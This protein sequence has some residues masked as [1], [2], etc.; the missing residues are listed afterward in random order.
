[1]KVSNETKI[2]ALTVITIVLLFFGFNFLK[3][4]NV[5]Q[6]GFILKAKFAKSKGIQP[7]N[8]V[9]INGFQ[10]GTVSSIQAGD[11]DLSSV[12]V[13]MKLNEAYNI[14]KNSLAIIQ[15]SPLGSSN[16]VIEKG[17]ASQYLAA[18]ES[19]NTSEGAAGIMA[20]LTD[21]LG[22]ISDGLTK[23]MVDFDSLLL[24]VN[25][26]LSEKNK[27]QISQM[28]ASVNTTMS[29]FAELSAEL[30]KMMNAQSGAIAKT[31][32][33][34]ATFTTNLN[35][36]NEKINNSVT[37]LQTMTKNL[38]EADIKGMM[39]NMNA[40][41]NSL[42]ASMEK[43]NSTDGTVGALLNDRT[44]YNRINATINSMNILLDDLRVHPKRYVNISVF[45][46]KDK[47]NY[48]QTPLATDSTK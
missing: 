7:S 5:F 40:S 14:P 1:M 47:G 21:K 38:S 22:P 41:V 43:L 8:P 26:V 9:T 29:H 23:S 4:K 44:M 12:I 15:S 34:M 33:N 10:V 17:D 2:G 28:L 18:G 45:G 6:S 37:N 48:L 32:N 39:A 13:E 25:T 27:S 30:Q 42:K 35:T 19:I 16:V 24:N 20:Q 36:N 11:K 3:G 46:R 31:M